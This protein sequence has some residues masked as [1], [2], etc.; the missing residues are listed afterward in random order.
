MWRLIGTMA[1]LGLSANEPTALLVVLVVLQSGRDRGVAFVSGWMAAL[2]A[3][4]AGAGFL[5][6]LGVGARPGGPRRITLVVELLIGLGLIAWATWYWFRNRGRELSV[7][8]PKNLVRLTSI[9]LVPALFAGVVTCTYPP[10][11][12]AGTTLFRSDAS[13]GGRLVGLA[14]FVIVG[15][16]MVALPVVGTY[17]APTWAAHHSNGL[18]NWTI[19]HRRTL[20]VVIL[21]AVGLF[22]SVRAVVLLVTR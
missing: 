3:V 16:L 9:G 8:V 15:T 12:V 2:V 5:V 17:V 10:A 21:V 11:I 14:I 1:V 7:E 13:V 19:R 20:L 6:R 22:I 4:V 18:F